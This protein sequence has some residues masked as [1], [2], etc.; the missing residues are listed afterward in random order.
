MDAL[1]MHAEDATG[2]GIPRPVQLFIPVRD[3]HTRDFFPD[4]RRVLLYVYPAGS[5]LGQSS[6]TALPV[7]YEGSVTMTNVV[8]DASAQGRPATCRINDLGRPRIELLPG[9]TVPA[10][11]GEI[12]QVVIRFNEQGQ[13]ELPIFHAAGQHPKMKLGVEYEVIDRDEADREANPKHDRWAETDGTGGKDAP[14]LPEYRAPRH[15]TLNAEIKVPSPNLYQGDIPQLLRRFLYSSDLFDESAVADLAIAG[16]DPTKVLSPLVYQ[17]NY[18]LSKE[19]MA[20]VEKQLKLFPN[21]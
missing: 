5:L 19:T 13:G 14:P 1:V 11:G 7:A 8:R 4:G 20:R 2:N 15:L 17:V 9:G 21:A 12:S 18:W 3:S 6:P 16:P 10:P